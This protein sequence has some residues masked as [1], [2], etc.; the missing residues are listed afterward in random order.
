MPGTTANYA[1]PYQLLTD[2]PNGASLGHD[3]LIA[4]DTT[5]AALAAT[6][7]ANGTIQANGGYGRVGTVSYVNGAG[8]SV[9]SEF[10]LASGT[11]TLAAGRIYRM[12]LTG[13]LTIT[14]GTVGA[15]TGRYASGGTVTT[16]GTLAA[17]LEFAGT[18]VSEDRARMVEFTSPGAG[19]Y[20]FGLFCQRVSGAGSV[21]VNNNTAQADLLILEDVGHP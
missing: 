11:F 2:A 10:L 14:S 9:T 16:A 8:G 15:F 20:T 1:W 17:E 18:G 13:V 12:T 5:V 7:A 21:V 3:G 4:A 6:V 19:S